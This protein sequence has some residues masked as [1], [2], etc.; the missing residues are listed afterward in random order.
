MMDGIL[1]SLYADRKDDHDHD[2]QKRVNAFKKVFG[3]DEGKTVLVDLLK[4]CRFH[5]SKRCLTK[6]GAVD[7]AAVLLSEGR[8]EVAV[9]IMWML[10]KNLR[11][12]SNG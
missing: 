1:E 11:G 3:T 2:L 7:Q 12:K 10:N 4:Y 5:A 6:E 9:Y 8:A